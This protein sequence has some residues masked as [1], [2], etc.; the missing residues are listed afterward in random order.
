MDVKYVPT[1]CYVGADGEKFYQYTMIEEAS[2]ERFICAYKEA[3]SYSTV[4]RLKG[5]F[6]WDNI[7]IASR[8][9]TIARL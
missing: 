4:T 9:K 8:Q 6:A 5:T 7:N 1:A 3:S 2:R